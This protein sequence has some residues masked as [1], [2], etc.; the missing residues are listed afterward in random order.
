MN[1][2]GLSIAS[3]VLGILSLVMSLLAILWIP[4]LIGLVFSI[5][6][7][8]LSIVARKGGDKSGIS[9]GGLVTN[10]VGLVLC[11]VF[12]IACAATFFAANS[13]IN[14]SDFSSIISSTQSIIDSISSM[15]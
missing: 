4:A 11:A 7:L 1:K 9:T 5:V 14:S 15:E 3:L 10:I 2:K 12:S 6:G 8:I 13:I